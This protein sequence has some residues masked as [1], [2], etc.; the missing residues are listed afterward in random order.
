MI[1]LN[2]YP[3]VKLDNGKRVV[4]YSSPRPYTFHTGE[5][6]PASKNREDKLSIKE[7]NFL[8][9]LDKVDIIL[10]SSYV[11]WN[12]QSMDD[13]DKKVKLLSKLRHVCWYNKNNRIIKSNKFVACG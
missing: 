13:Q 8:V 6:L 4:N 1:F 9:E 11:L 7:L 12:I 2:K 5:V 10:V 3:T